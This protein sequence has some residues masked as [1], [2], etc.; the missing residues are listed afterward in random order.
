MP[1][2]LTDTAP[3]PVCEIPVIVNGAAVFTKE[4]TP[5]PL[6]EPLKLVTVFALPKV[7]PVAELVVSRP[8]FNKPAPASLMAPAVPVSEIPPVVFILPAFNVT[9]RPAVAL[10]APDVLPTLALKRI[11][12]VVPVA[13]KV[14]LPVKPPAGTTETLLVV[15]LPWATDRVAGEAVS[16]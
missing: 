9:L 6:F 3:V 1:V 15:V 4:I 14:T 2:L 7:V 13:D 11:S 10:T 8:P 12:L 5:A 16:V